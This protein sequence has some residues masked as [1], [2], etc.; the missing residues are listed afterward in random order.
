[1]DR[2]VIKGKE[3]FCKEI[4][5]ISM[6]S[7]IDK[8]NS[9]FDRRYKD[10][11]NQNWES[12]FAEFDTFLSQ[13]NG[14][15]GGITR[16]PENLEIKTLPN[17]SELCH[18]LFR[19]CY[20][21]DGNAFIQILNMEAL[22]KEEET[23]TLDCAL[24]S[25]SLL[26]Y[27]QMVIQ[28][29]GDNDEEYRSLVLE[30]YRPYI[31]SFIM[32]VEP[33]AYQKL[34]EVYLDSV[35]E[36]ENIDNYMYFSC[37]F[38]AINGEELVYP[39]YV[40]ESASPIRKYETYIKLIEN[41]AISRRAVDKYIQNYNLSNIV[42]DA[43]FINKLEASWSKIRVSKLEAY[44]IGNGNCI[45]VEGEKNCFF[46]DVG[47]N[48]RHRPQ[49]INSGKSYNYQSSM[50]QI[51]KR[52]PEFIIL[53]HW[54]MDH[55]AGCA[56]TCRDIFDK[57]WFAPDCEDAGLN[58]KRLAKYLDMKDNLI[59]VSRKNG[60][61]LGT[62]EISDEHDVSRTIA[63]YKFYIGEKSSCDRSLPNCQGIAILMKDYEKEETILMLGDVNYE[64]FNR[65]RN[66]SGDSLIENMTIDY[67]IAPHHG[68]ERTNYG[69]LVG[70]RLTP[71]N[72]TTAIVC[73]TNDVAANRPNADHMANLQARFTKS[74]LTTEEASASVSGDD[75]GIVI[76]I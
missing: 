68:S 49:L 26:E 46:Y 44:K 66:N 48:Y 61:C 50:R 55:I 52:K 43:V 47:F 34:R 29:L 18:S 30:Y 20:Y 31:F 67:L 9:R 73:C 39:G 27:D 40:I 53:S 15:A 19:D 60:R 28:A 69:L 56:A 12:W 13:E 16:K 37:S 62:I 45:C 32:E 6:M 25:R 36:L 64:S 23:I 5:K 70:N 24:F 54:D 22:E 14:E 75:Y 57:K 58:A 2:D 33:G 51:A 8:W 59:R 4:R 7:E 1:M 21:G 38:N 71:V 11:K 17:N 63:S 41:C 3:R 65:A 10:F 42:T 72:G 35:G 74:V 76:S